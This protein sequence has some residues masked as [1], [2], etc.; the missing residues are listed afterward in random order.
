MAAKWPLR[1]QPSAI[2]RHSVQIRVSSRGWCYILEEHGLLKGDFDKAQKLITA[3]RK[4]GA[5][6]LDICVED[7]RRVADG[8]EEIDGDDVENYATGIIDYVRNG[9][10]NYTPASF[11]EAQ[12]YYVELAVEKID[13]KSLFASVCE[14]FRMAIRNIGGWSDINSRAAMMRRFADWEAK[15]KQCVLLYCGDHD[16]GRLQISSFMRPNLAELEGAVGW[17]PENLIIERFGLNADFIDA[18][19]LTWIDNLA[20]S[21]ETYPLDDPRHADFQKPY[22]QDYLRQFGAHK[23]EANAL[24]VRPEAGREL[25]RGAILRYIPESSIAEYENDL[26]EERETL[27]I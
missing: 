15:G 1:M 20:T 13:L 12:D 22:V 5:L 23:V 21:H 24:L 4:N 25:C 18:Q 10:V 17:S 8:V 19:R 9:H 11:W 2:W 14:P 7:E 26:A 6:P 27:R 3:G 16:P